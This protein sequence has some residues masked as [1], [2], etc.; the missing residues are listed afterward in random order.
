MKQKFHLFVIHLTTI[1]LQRTCNLNPRTGWYSALDKSNQM[2]SVYFAIHPGRNPPPQNGCRL[3]FVFIFIFKSTGFTSST[4][5]IQ[6]DFSQNQ[7]AAI[8]LNTGSPRTLGVGLCP[9]HV[10]TYE[11]HFPFWANTWSWVF[12][13]WLKNLM[14]NEVIC[15]INE[16]DGVRSYNMRGQK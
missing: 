2:K 10:C 3:K 16:Q 4:F 8:T 11:T 14:E 12:P 15:L 7:P 9:L 13:R 5:P 6:P 1:S